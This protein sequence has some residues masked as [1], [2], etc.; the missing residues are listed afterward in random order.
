MA[1]SKILR[2]LTGVGTVGS[3]KGKVRLA[4]GSKRVLPVSIKLEG[5]ADGK[6]VAE[7]VDALA[8]SG[9]GKFRATMLAANEGT[10][11]RSGTAADEELANLVAVAF[12]VRDDEAQ[13]H[14][15]EE[16]ERIE[17]FEVKRVAKLYLSSPNSDVA[18]V[19]DLKSAV[20][21]SV[22]NLETVSPESI[23]A[24]AEAVLAVYAD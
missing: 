16:L 18:N 15:P 19:A 2:T 24:A 21:R 7:L 4:D 9:E 17:A 12:G 5:C 3:I 14:T 8:V 20:R 13:E 10:Y 1:T 6:T 23:R 22:A 11:T